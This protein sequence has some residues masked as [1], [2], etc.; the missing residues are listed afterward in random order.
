[1]RLILVALLMAGTTTAAI[2][3]TV[4]RGERP[5]SSI[6]ATA[7]DAATGAA[8]WRS[9]DHAFWGTDHRGGPLR[10]DACSP[11]EFVLDPMG[12][13]DEAAADLRAALAMLAE[14]SGLHL[15]LAGTI[16]ERPDLDRP[17]VE[18][19]AGG[20]RWR[21]VLVAWAEPGTSSVPLDDLDRGI[22]LPVAVR[23]GEREAFVTGQV[24]INAR[25]PDLVAG[26][27]DRSSS[28]G[29][30]LVHEVGH[31]LGLDHVAAPS[32]L[33]SVA[34]GRGPVVL[35]AGD[36]AG[37]RAVGAPAGCNPAPAPTAGRGLSVRR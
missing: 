20:W 25:R 18:A 7:N 14:A 30:T 15:V 12:A 11:I 3:L 16:D 2:A 33:M 4:L 28:L 34:P 23:D 22:A 5:A 21:P 17:L 6:G 24:I 36:R 9:G 10:W 1:V 32:Q 31:I 8:P 29:A 27:E 13:P 19:V 26:F 37:L 35:G